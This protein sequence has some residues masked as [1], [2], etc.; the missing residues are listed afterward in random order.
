MC[1]GA[2]IEHT[3]IVNLISL[4][5]HK[6]TDMTALSLK[7]QQ[8]RTIKLFDSRSNHTRIDKPHNKKDNESK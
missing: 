8:K 6:M 1:I 4:T 7:L 3:Q 2:H 5:I